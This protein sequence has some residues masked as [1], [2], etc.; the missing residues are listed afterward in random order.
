MDLFHILVIIISI[1]VF[2]GL[3]LFTAYTFYQ[4]KNTIYPPDMTSC[5]DFWKV[6]SDGTCQI[7]RRGEQNLGHLLNKGRVMYEYNFGTRPQYSSLQKFFNSDSEKFTGSAKKE[8]IGYYKT[9][10]PYGY[11][12]DNPKNDSINFNDPE[13]ASSGDPYCAIKKWANVNNIQWDGMASY[14]RC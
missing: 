12:H 6:R 10:I 9:D 8:L 1:T 13:W 2:I 14:N 11:D 5:P 3:F 7:P 4:N